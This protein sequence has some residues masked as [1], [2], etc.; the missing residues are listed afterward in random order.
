MR[1]FFQYTSQI[2]YLL[3]VLQTSSF[4]RQNNGLRPRWKF[5]PWYCWIRSK[6]VAPSTTIRD[7]ENLTFII[8]LDHLLLCNLGRIL[9][10]TFDM[11]RHNRRDSAAPW[12]LGVA[13]FLHFWR[14]GRNQMQITANSRYIKHASYRSWCIEKISATISE[15]QTINGTKNESALVL[16]IDKN[17]RY[18]G[19]SLL[20]GTMAQHRSLNLYH[21]HIIYD[22]VNLTG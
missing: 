7:V 22:I 16:S 20:I 21:F 14:Q 12:L 18:Q 2:S 4:T 1:V 5:K 15:V 10:R 13:T 11:I 19:V 9:I 8:L 6:S 3:T 17:W